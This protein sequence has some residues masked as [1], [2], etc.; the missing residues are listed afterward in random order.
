VIDAIGQGHKRRPQLGRDSH[1]LVYQAL[2][3]RE[4]G[5]GSIGAIE[6]QVGM[7]LLLDYSSAQE[8]TQLSL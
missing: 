8:T 2:Q 4:T 6:D 1:G 7:A 3:L 5:V